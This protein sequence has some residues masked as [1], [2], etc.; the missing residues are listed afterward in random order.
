MIDIIPDGL[1]TGRGSELSRVWFFRAK[2]N[3]CIL[4]K[5]LDASLFI[6]L[7]DGVRA[8]VVGFEFPAS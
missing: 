8:R 7:E 1:V 2:I 4:E 6:L 5:D 3:D